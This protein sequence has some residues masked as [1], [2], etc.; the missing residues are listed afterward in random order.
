MGGIVRNLNESKRFGDSTVV[1][2]SIVARPLAQMRAGNTL[3]IE[4]DDGD[5]VFYLAKGTIAFYRFMSDAH[6]V[7]CGFALAGEVFSMSHGGKYICTAEALS[8]CLYRRRSRKEVESGDTADIM[9]AK[10]LAA[11]RSELWTM[12]LQTLRRL[13]LSADDN[14]ANFILEIGQR[15]N[16]GLTNGSTVHLDMSRADIAS[17]LGLTVETVVRSLKRLTADG[18]LTAYTPHEFGIRDI[19]GLYARVRPRGAVAD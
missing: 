1:N 10:H 19:A 17:Y 9:Q 11:L 4:D 7:T 12:Q 18:L 15:A 3:F 16:P 8:D 5:D 2:L 14:V 6:R 13:H